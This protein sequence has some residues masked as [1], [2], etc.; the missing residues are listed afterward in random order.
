MWMRWDDRPEDSDTVKRSA[1][2]HDRAA[3]DGRYEVGAP[4]AGVGPGRFYRGHETATG[5]EVAVR[6]LALRSQPAPAVLAAARQA[7]R[8]CAA[9]PHP[10]ITRTFEIDQHEDALIVVTE[11]RGTGLSARWQ[12]LSPEMDAVLTM[13]R[14][15][16]GALAFIHA[17]HESY[18]LLAPDSV[19]L[20]MR[21]TARLA[22]VGMASLA[23]YLCEPLP[24]EFFT[25]PGYLAPEQER[26]DALGPATDVYHLGALLWKLLHAALPADA[27]EELLPPLLRDVLARCLSAN[28]ASRPQDL[29]AVSDSLRLAQRQMHGMGPPRAMARVQI[30]RRSTQPLAETEPTLPALPPASRPGALQVV[31]DRSLSPVDWATS[32]PGWPALAARLSGQPPAQAEDLDITTH[33]PAIEKAAAP[34]KEPP[35]LEDGVPSPAER[36]P[37][38]EAARRRTIPRW[39][40]A[41]RRMSGMRARRK[42]V[43]ASLAIVGIVALATL[44]YSTGAFASDAASQ[45]SQGLVHDTGVTTLTARAAPYRVSQTL[46][47]GTGQ[48]LRVQAGATLAF[49]PGTGIVVRGGT[50]EV[51]GTS[52]TPVILTAAGDP[53]LGGSG[54]AAGVWL[55]ILSQTGADG[56][57]SHVLLQNAAIRFAGAPKSA[58]IVCEAGD[59]TLTNSVQSDSAGSG[60]VAAANCWGDVE[61]TTFERDAA[62]AADVTSS[63]LQFIDNVALGSTVSLP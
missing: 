49:A 52:T 26:G 51:D 53:A 25:D 34:E 12:A 7:A 33:H 39:L 27:S 13:G 10:H 21:G 15:L 23:E 6:V 38:A 63:A 45:A 55:G 58:A 32:S 44:V 59:L 1:V 18:G 48:T 22:D 29:I 46:A 8:R 19:E 47:I 28:P 17:Q 36:A 54:A 37:Q 31:P 14:Q 42:A 40:R 11:P 56:T 9:S 60:L 35:A 43:L 16:C 30:M 57:K 61:S 2:W 20:T 5:K 62:D 24:A 4:C 41:I 50:F 3:L